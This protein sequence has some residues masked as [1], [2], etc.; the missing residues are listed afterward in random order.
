M[1][2][3]DQE[4]PPHSD[5]K[6]W[7]RKLRLISIDIDPCSHERCLSIR[8][9]R[10]IAVAGTDLTP[11]PGCMTMAWHQA[12][13]PKSYNLMDENAS[14]CIGAARQPARTIMGMERR[15]LPMQAT[16]RGHIDVAPPEAWCFERP[17]ARFPRGICRKSD[18]GRATTEKLELV[19]VNLE[20]VLRVVL[21]GCHLPHPPW[22][23]RRAVQGYH[24]PHV[25]QLTCRRGWSQSENSPPREGLANPLQIQRGRRIST[26][27][28]SQ[29][30]HA[31]PHLSRSIRNSSHHAGMSQPSSSNE[32]IEISVPDS[33]NVAFA[34]GRPFARC[35]R[36]RRKRRGKCLG[37]GGDSAMHRRP[38]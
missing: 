15:R 37:R 30:D 17:R 9:R 6:K 11:R 26:I 29:H 5:S 3:G 32:S 24:Q 13:E 35:R 4:R 12:L 2:Q 31:S 21:Q 23:E 34:H 27:F 38:R 22:P 10:T 14:G 8:Y 36:R 19:K 28:I 33:Q 20:V 16:R 25:S 1:P 7:R 18:D